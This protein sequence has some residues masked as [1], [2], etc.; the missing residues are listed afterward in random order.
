MT[1][2]GKYV[3][4]VGAVRSGGLQ[5]RPVTTDKQVKAKFTEHL[6]EAIQQEG[7]K[8]SKHAYKRII[9]RDIFIDDLRWQLI[10][11]KVDEARKKGVTDSLV[12]LDDAALIVSTKN[13]TVITAMDRKEAGSQIF[14]NINGTIVID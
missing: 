11:Q 6:Q 5:S 12:L 3:P 10:T 9:Q 14:T 1:V 4:P 2:H 7:L 13:K 8:I